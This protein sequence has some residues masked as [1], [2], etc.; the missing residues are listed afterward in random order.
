MGCMGPFGSQ[1]VAQTHGDLK[2]VMVDDGGG[3]TLEMR[4]GPWAV[5]ATETWMSFRFGVN[6]SV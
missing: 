2:V 1:F 5:R 6:R 3:F 4:A